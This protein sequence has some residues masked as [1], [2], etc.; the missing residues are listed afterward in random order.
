MGQSSR[1]TLGSSESESSTN[2][3]FSKYSRLSCDGTTLMFTGSARCVAS[4]KSAGGTAHSQRKVSAN[5]NAPVVDP[6][7][8]PKNAG[9]KSKVVRTQKTMLLNV[10]RRLRPSLGKSPLESSPRSSVQR[11]SLLQGGH[12]VRRTSLDRSPL[13]SSPRSSEKKHTH[14]FPKKFCVSCHTVQP[15]MVQSWNNQTSLYYNLRT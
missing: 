4:F 11:K 2:I 7:S 13:N 5:E 12:V 6:L 10:T 14:E 8:G 1:N 3:L 15:V 9:I